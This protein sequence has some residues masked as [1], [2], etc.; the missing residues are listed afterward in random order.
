MSNRYALVENGVVVNVILWDGD[1]EAWQPPEGATAELLPAD[2][3]VSI[4][5]T[6]NGT[7]FSPPA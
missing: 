3:P 6:F 5:F 2:S 7:M 4:G 1:T